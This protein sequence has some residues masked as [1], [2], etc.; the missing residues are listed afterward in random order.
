[1]ERTL[2]VIETGDRFELFLAVSDEK[3]AWGAI[4][5]PQPLRA[6]PEHRNH[7]VELSSRWE[8]LQ[9]HIDLDTLPASR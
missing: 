3:T 8:S 4:D 6:S 7:A 1:M 9:A 5:T 2:V